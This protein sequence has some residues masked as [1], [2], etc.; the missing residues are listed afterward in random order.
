MKKKVFKT[1]EGIQ[2]LSKNKINKKELEKLVME[3]LG[4]CSY[5]FEESQIIGRTRIRDSKTIKVKYYEYE[6]TLLSSS[7]SF[8][9]NNI[10]E[11]NNIF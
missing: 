1:K 4:K 9:V 7:F 10:V 6:V 3:E 8:H 11:G 2:V 5:S